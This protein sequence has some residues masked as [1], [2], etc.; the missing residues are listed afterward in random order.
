MEMNAEKETDRHLWK[1]MEELERR[2][3]RI[4]TSLQIDAPLEHELLPVAIEPVAAVSDSEEDE[5]E[6]AIGQTWFAKLGIIVLAMGVGFLLTRPFGDLPP[7]APGI[8]GY[9]LV[10]TIFLLSHIFRNAFALVSN[11][12]R[13]AA[14]ALLYFATLRL[15]FFGPAPTLNTDSVFGVLLLVAIVFI[16]MVIAARRKSVFLIGLS[17]LTGYATSILV[18][19]AAFLFTTNVILVGLTVYF[20]LRH[21]W[22]KLLLYGMFLTYTTHLLWAFNNPI[23]GHEFRLVTEPSINF[24]LLLVYAGM[25]A[26]GA[27][28]RKERE[29]ENF[30]VLLSSFI[31]GSASYGIFLILTLGASK[32]SFELFHLAASAGYL[33]LAVFFWMREK[34]RYSTFIYAMMGYAALSVALVNAFPIP[35]VFVWLSIQSILVV[36]T[37]VWFRSRFVVVANFVIFLGIVGAFLIG[38]GPKSGVSV[39]FGI[40]ALLTARILSWQQHRLELKTEMMRNAY[41]ATALCVLPYAIYHLTPVEYVTIAWVGLALFYYLMNLIVKKQKYRWMGHLTLVLTIV[42]VLIIGIIQLEPT[43][44]IISFLVLGMALLIVSLVFTRLR[45]RRRSG[46]GQPPND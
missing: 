1:K 12:L 21:D 34:S 46:K 26:V 36:A 40:V 6:F 28:L 30:G 35:D 32:E 15:Y 37:A 41:L 18:D 11:Y 29:S 3:K 24:F 2:L 19:S 8:F 42:Y 20:S 17:L 44:R 38:A 10:G 9:F 27:M 43:Y 14:M 31:N 23:M 16:N 33:A 5:L 39:V 22:F 45:A 7:A 13:G 25:F 4:E